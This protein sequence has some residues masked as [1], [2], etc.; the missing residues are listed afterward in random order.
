MPTP[1][2]HPSLKSHLFI[3]KRQQQQQQQQRQ[4]KQK[5][6]EDQRAA[7]GAYWKKK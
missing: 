1:S 2:P 7:Q 6:T 4:Q 5:S 3:A